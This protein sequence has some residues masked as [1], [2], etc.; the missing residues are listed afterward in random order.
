MAPRTGLDDC[1]PPIPPLLSTPHIFITHE[2]DWENGK[3]RGNEPSGRASAGRSERAWVRM[4]RLLWESS[5]RLTGRIQPSAA[6]RAPPA[7][8]AGEAARPPAAPGAVQTAP[9]APTWAL[10]RAAR[11]SSAH[12]G[13]GSPAR[14]CPAASPPPRSPVGGALAASSRPARPRGVRRGRQGQARRGSA[15]CPWPGACRGRGDG[16]APRLPSP[17]RLPGSAPGGNDVLLP[18]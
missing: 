11:L 14:A 9:P 15:G 2:A 17:S 7:V 10:T 13:R 6:R 3:L 12:P 16:P 1:R 8:P 5:L 18:G 4:P